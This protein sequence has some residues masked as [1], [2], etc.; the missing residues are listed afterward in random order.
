MGA[1]TDYSK[2]K[3]YKI[4]NTVND[5]VYVGSTTISLSQRMAKHRWSAKTNTKHCPLYQKIQELGID[6][7]YIELIENFPCSTKEELHARE[8][9]FIREIGTLNK[10]VAGRKHK[11][12]KKDNAEHV[13]EH[14]KQYYENNRE[15]I[16]TRVI[17]WTKN[18]KEKKAETDKAYREANHDKIRERIK[19]WR[20]KNKDKIREQKKEWSEKNEDKIKQVYICGVCGGRYQNKRKDEH[21]RTKKH[22]NELNS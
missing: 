9:H 20:E 19:E 5:D 4:L 11:E 7:F 12:W 13:Q 8:G 2:G 18:N 6:K 3:I 15:T 22:Q 10:I 1:K 14:A 17:E 21:F 16:K